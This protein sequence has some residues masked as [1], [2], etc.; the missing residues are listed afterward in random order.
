MTTYTHDYVIV[1][2]R[3][4]RGKSHV[5]TGSWSEVQRGFDF[6]YFALLSLYDIECALM[7]TI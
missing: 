1:P 7:L 4:S 5:F 6:F 3:K 2:R